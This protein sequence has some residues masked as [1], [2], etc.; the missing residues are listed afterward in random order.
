VSRLG[1]SERGHVYSLDGKRVPS[2]SKI[3]GAPNKA[4]MP[5]AAAREAALWA[6][7]HRDAY[8][9]MGDDAWLRT[10]AN[11]HRDEWNRR[12]DDGRLVHVL[13]ESLVYGKT[14]PA[15][16]D[17]EP[18]PEHVADMAEQLARFFDAWN[19]DPVEHERMVWH[20]R[21]RYAGRFD[22]LADFGAKRWLIDYKTGASGVWPETSLQLTGYRYATHWV[23][24]DN[25]DRP[26][27]ELGIDDTAAVWLRPDSWELLPVRS[28][29]TAWQVFTHCGAVAAWLDWKR[30]ASV[31]DPLP[32]PEQ[33]AS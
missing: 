31:F 27:A 32:R 23:D 24:G 2:V 22:L 25:V 17:G 29:E 30:E 28:D 9:V 3:A 4:A 20:E 12:A 16:H 11:A 33:V 8:D 6:S 5:Y 13:A 14:M 26:I 1:F 18:V 10:A 15:V 19:V 21:Y 7:L